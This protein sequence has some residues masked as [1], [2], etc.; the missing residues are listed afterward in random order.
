[1][2]ANTSIN[3]Q[4]E[5][6][7]LNL[8]LHRAVKYSQILIKKQ[9]ITPED[10]GCQ[11]WIASKLDNLGFDVEQYQINAVSNLIAT[12]GKESRTLAY[13]GHTDVVPVNDKSLWK[14]EPFEAKII[15]DVLVGR[16]AVDMKTS[17]GAMLAAME[18]VIAQGHVP[19]IQ[20]QVLLTSD[21][22]GEAEFGTKTIIEKLEKRE[23][24]PDYCLVGEPTSETQSGDI[25]KVG[26]RGSISGKL[27]VKGKQGHVAYAGINR[28]AIH[29]ASEIIHAL[30]DIDWDAGSD[31][32]PGT[33]LQV[34]YV[35]S[36]EFTDNITPGKCEVC[37]NIRFSHRYDLK[38][39][40]E[41]VQDQIRTLS[42]ADEGLRDLNIE[43]DR[44][45]APYFTYNDDDSCFISVVESA[46]HKVTGIFPRLSTSG[47]TSDGRFISSKNTQ[48]LELGLPN[49]TIHQVNERVRLSEIVRLYDIYKKILLSF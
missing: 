7:S 42:V 25:M 41:A 23:C 16:G 24:C 14:V 47:G 37:F 10:A 48:V 19:S 6:S 11:N 31:D 8:A 12:R 4:R 46:I 15:N 21:E 33:T 44:Y 3:A 38:D 9:S 45:C 40:Q 35:N 29:L 5:H 36:G 20:W 27:E 28:N 1:M 30:E 26:R 39:V 34:T 32:F 43:W 22:E 49:N 17:L 13:A 2:T 18:D